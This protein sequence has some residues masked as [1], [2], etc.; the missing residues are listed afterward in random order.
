MFP[1]ERPSP[2]SGQSHPPAA[3]PAA[4]THIVCA[5][6]PDA[7]VKEYEK[8]RRP[9]AIVRPEWVVDSIRAG[10]LLPV[11]RGARCPSC[12]HCLV[13]CHLSGA[14]C[15]H[16]GTAAAHAFRQDGR[17]TPPFLSVS[18]LWTDSLPPWAQ[19]QDYALQQLRDAPGQRKLKAFQKASSWGGIEG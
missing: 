16:V 3:P 14:G 11:S 2:Y 6:L 12:G 13:A 10:H 5:N 8:A 7:K 18:A 1:A 9:P 19:T 17:R 4:V 15:L